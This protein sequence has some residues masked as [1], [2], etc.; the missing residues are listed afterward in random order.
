MFSLD[1]ARPDL[2]HNDPQVLQATCYMCNIMMCDAPTD[3]RRALLSYLQLRKSPPGFP[4][5]NDDSTLASLK[6]VYA[7][8]VQSDRKRTAEPLQGRMPFEQF[9]S[10]ITEQHNTCAIT[11][12]RG[13]W[14]QG[15]ERLATDESLLMLSVDSQQ[16]H[17][18][19][20]T[21][22]SFSLG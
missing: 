9:V 15:K 10:W 19:L 6:K 1:H 20:A 7:A 17:T 8:M 11:G 18:A 5:D 4:S 14:S 2:G 3:E 16:P 12:I 22:R 13:A 21:C